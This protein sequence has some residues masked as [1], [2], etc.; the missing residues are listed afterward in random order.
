MF[1]KGA[2][3]GPGQLSYAY[4]DRV[5]G[6]ETV[7]AGI[8]ISNA[9]RR[10]RLVCKSFT[11]IALLLEPLPLWVSKAWEGHETALSYHLWQL[12]YH[13]WQFPE[14]ERNGEMAQG[15]IGKIGFRFGLVE[16]RTTNLVPFCGFREAFIQ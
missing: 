5:R 4:S 15:A 16:R 10:I 6:T 8:A 13:L 9:G 3:P 14:R 11:W 1:F 7:R 2:E 12:S